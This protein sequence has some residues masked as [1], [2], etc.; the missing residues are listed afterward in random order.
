MKRLLLL[1][2]TGSTSPSGVTFLRPPSLPQKGVEEKPRFPVLMFRC[3]PDYSIISLFCAS[4]K[5]KP[6]PMMMMTLSGAEQRL[7]AGI[8][9][10][11]Q[12]SKTAL[13]AGSDSVLTCYNSR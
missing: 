8:H 13:C 2:A 3:T 9:V 7:L 1:V 4:I 6:T 12:H 11:R 5:N 10:D